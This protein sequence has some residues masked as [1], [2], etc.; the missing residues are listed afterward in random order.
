MLM[1]R[2]GALLGGKPP[3]DWRGWCSENPDWPKLIESLLTDIEWRRDRVCIDDSWDLIE[4]AEAAPVDIGIKLPEPFEVLEPVC[5]TPPALPPPAVKIFN[6]EKIRV[7]ERASEGRDSESKARM[8]EIVRRLYDAS[9][10]K[11]LVVVPSNW[12]QLLDQ[13]DVDFPNFP[14]VVNFLRRQCALTSRGDGRLA[15]PPMLFD[16]D[17]GVGKTEFV[18]ALAD[19][20][21]TTAVVIDMASAQSGAALSGSETFWAN[22]RPG[23][24]FETL[25]FG[26]QANIIVI[27]EEIDKT[28]RDQ[29]YSPEGPLHLLLEPLT[30]SKFIDLSVREVQLDASHI[31][32]V[33]TTNHVDLLSAP[34]RQRFTVFTIPTPTFEQTQVI[35]KA[36]YRRLLR[37][38]TWGGTFEPELSDDVAKCLAV[39]SPRKIR[40]MLPSA[41]GNA[42]LA[43]RD[44]VLVED[45]VDNDPIATSRSIGFTGGHGR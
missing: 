18:F 20:F 34:L 22:S 12:P 35:A 13:L 37:Q 8:K 10:Y 25:A 30:A 19:L 4:G 31:L 3:T 38:G 6:E 41:L 1:G 11:S 26:E 29:Y 24:I 5:D 2:F 15:W 16:G 14:E 17:P 23:E 39:H 9:P 40:M 44:K 45:V 32:W 21:G 27:L 36:I 42:A 7:L 33:S 28:G 43:D